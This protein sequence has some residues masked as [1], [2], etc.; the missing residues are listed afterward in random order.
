MIM[1]RIT[2]RSRKVGGFANRLLGIAAK[3]LY[4]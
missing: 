3:R 4:R 2:I 1:S